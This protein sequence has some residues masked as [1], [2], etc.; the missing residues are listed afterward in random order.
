MV[1]VLNPWV[2]TIVFTVLF[3]LSPFI[4]L[5]VLTRFIKDKR[6]RKIYI[7]SILISLFG[8]IYMK[9]E[10]ILKHNAEMKKEKLNK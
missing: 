10:K 8:L 9:K 4:I 7:F 6:T 2:L 3:Y 5:L 1:S